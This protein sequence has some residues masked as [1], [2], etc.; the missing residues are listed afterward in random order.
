VWNRKTIIG[1]AEIQVAWFS[2][3]P[4]Q[5]HKVDHALACDMAGACERAGFMSLTFEDQ[6]YELLPEFNWDVRSHE[7]GA[8]VHLLDMSVSA[9]HVVA[10]AEASALVYRAKTLIGEPALYGCLDDEASPFSVSFVG[11]EKGGWRSDCDTG[12]EKLLSLVLSNDSCLTE[13]ILSAGHVNVNVWLE[14][15]KPVTYLAI[16]TSKRYASNEE[17]TEFVGVSAEIARRIQ[18]I[19]EN[20]QPGEA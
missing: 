14:G 8:A 11:A 13:T 15:F 2:K 12:L 18:S 1:S 17:L 20:L 7:A 3:K 4:V 6:D 10:V 9:L 5:R 19:D 16:N